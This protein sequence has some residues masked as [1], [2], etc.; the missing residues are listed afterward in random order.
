MLLFRRAQFARLVLICLKVSRMAPSPEGY[1]YDVVIP[2]FNSEQIVGETIAETARFFENR[3]WR[4]KLILVNDGSSDRS[5]EVLERAAAENPNV[6]AIDLLKNYGQHTAVY[7]G[8]HHS[9]ADFV[10]TMDDDLQNPPSEIEHLV[11]KILE[12]YDVVFGKFR[13]KQHET[14]RVAGSRIVQFINRRVFEYDKDLTVTNFRI[15]KREVVKAICDYRT[16]FPYINGLSLMFS[17][18]RANVLVEHHP[19][20]V[21]KSNYNLSRIL[22]LVMRILFNYSPLPLRVVSTFGFAVAG[23]AFLL[24][25]F[26]FA[27]ALI[28]GTSVPGWASQTVLLAFFSGVNIVI[29][30]MLGEYV[31]RLMQ[32]VSHLNIYNVRK[33]LNYDE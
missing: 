8:F 5:W 4:Y 2:V 30:S 11:N 6:V 21:G 24:S 33:R 13:S 32:Q 29:V 7:V 26:V 19:R 31:T 1:S 3:N 27:K 18:H 28:V 22:T 17:Y 10:I 20:K 14:Y 12:G 15:L 23:V 25:I 16:V 9:T